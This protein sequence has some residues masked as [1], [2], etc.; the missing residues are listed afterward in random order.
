MGTGGPAW[1]NPGRMLLSNVRARESF[2]HESV[3]FAKAAGVIAGL[4]AYGH[5]LAAQALLR[6]APP[7]AIQMIKGGLW[8][9]PAHRRSSIIQTGGRVLMTAAPRSDLF[10]R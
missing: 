9:I 4:G 10:G 1:R 3:L 6:K 8:G 7:E 5:R 2:R